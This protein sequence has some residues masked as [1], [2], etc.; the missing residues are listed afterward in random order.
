MDEV[1]KLIQNP[2][3]WGNLKMKEISRGMEMVEIGVFGWL[4]FDCFL[5]FQCPAWK[6][7][8][9]PIHSFIPMPSNFILDFVAPPT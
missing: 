1:V 3:K 7:K 6:W 8:W 4:V 2:S 9:K 5:I